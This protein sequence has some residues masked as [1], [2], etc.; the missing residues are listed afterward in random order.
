[1][2][3]HAN[4]DNASGQSE[5][6]GW[7]TLQVQIMARHADDLSPKKVETAAHVCVR[8]VQ[9][10]RSIAIRGGERQGQ[11]LAPV[12]TPSHYVNDGIVA[13]ER[14]STRLRE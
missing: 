11:A 4:K 8:I 3:Y 5:R 10:F 6:S 7:V 1:M 2:K 13:C 14:K 12:V 9:L